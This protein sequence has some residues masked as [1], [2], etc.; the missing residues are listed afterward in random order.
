MKKHPLIVLTALA[1]YAALGCDDTKP[2][3]RLAPSIQTT[4]SAMEF[5]EVPLGG[6]K[7]LPLS[8]EDSGELT[9][10]V[11]AAAPT[12]GSAADD[13]C[14]MVSRVEPSDAPFAPAFGAVTEQGSWLVEAGQK[15]ELLVRFTPKAVG[16][17]SGALQLFNNAG[18]RPTTVLLSGSGVQAD[19]ELSPAA[20]DFGDVTVGEKKSL[21]L[22][23]TNRANFAQSVSVGP[24][25]QFALVF[26]VSDAGGMDPPVG[27][28]LRFELGA[29][30]A[31]TVQVWFG[32]IEEGEILNQLPI[33]VCSVGG[34]RQEV[35]LRGV[36]LKPALIVSPATLDFGALESGLSSSKRFEAKNVGQSAVLVRSVELEAGSS[37]SYVLNPEQALPLSLAP[38]DTL[39]VG[40]R[41]DSGAPGT[42]PARVVV[43]SSAWDD[44]ATADAENAAVVT[45][46]GVSVGADIAALP[47]ALN[48]G[49]VAIGNGMASRVLTLVNQGNAPLTIRQI[50]LNGPSAEIELIRV[51]TTPLTLEGG[52]E[53]QVILRYRPQD[54]G[55][56]EAQVVVRSSDPDSD[57]LVVPVRGSGGTPSGCALTVTPLTVQFGVV[58][59][60]RVATLPVVV[61]DTGVAPCTLSNV[62][63]AGDT[64][65]RALNAAD[66]VLMPG[67]STRFD[68]TYTP[69]ESADASGPVSG[70]MNP[71]AG[72]IASLNAYGSLV[73]DSDDAS[74]PEL[75]VPL[76]GSS[77]VG[78]LHA[79]PSELDFSVIPPGCGSPS[80]AVM[81]Y[82]TGAT[83][84]T[85]L[86]AY[87]D[88]STSSEYELSPAP[89]PS[90]I[91]AGGELRLE[92]RYRPRDVG[93]DLGAL[94]IEHTDSLFPLMIPLRG[95]SD[96]APTLTDRFTQLPAPT[97]DVLFVV[98]NSG[99]MAEEQANLGANFGAFLSYAESTGVD[100]QIAVTTTDVDALGARGHFSR[101]GGSSIITPRTPDA[102]RVFLGNTNV[103][104]NGS[105]TEQ[106][107]EAAFLALSEPLI[108][109]SNR[110]FLRADASL[111]VIVVSDEEDQSGRTPA[112]Y[113]SFFWNIKG[114][115]NRAQFSFSAIV[116]PSANDPLCGSF[117]PSPG[118][119]YI[120][121]AQ[122]TGGVVESICT[123][124]WGA[125]LQNIGLGTFGL[126]SRFTLSAQAIPTSIV[127]SVDGVAMSSAGG[128]QWTYDAATNSLGFRPGFAPI[129]GAVVEVTYQVACVP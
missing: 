45:L 43:R 28:P 6:F 40:V 109:T 60:G 51:P 23:I 59:R 29:N 74:Q 105:S 57:P 18:E 128:A 88:A 102:A 71:P 126:R 16:P 63:V 37:P 93:E 77:A 67:T 73:F 56:D 13:A 112:F 99:S 129:A 11:C 14:T 111:A 72:A 21:E 76:M 127:V 44:P 86:R 1:G 83:A 107:L 96:F 98:D 119:R 70:G 84:V 53:V 38:G 12:E 46:S 92:L 123:A 97:V 89:I 35:G 27:E 79:L 30:A 94:F 48:F 68:L 91:P 47:A 61:S 64:A 85:V 10:V 87:L 54:S 4:P 81:L 80:R 100:Y 15:R 50:Q 26:G 90:S 58:E 108:S 95:R 114:F 78:A 125:T 36:G 113:E 17:I 104:T 49:T 3:R 116:V 117:G 32:P 7:D 122:A 120:E 42:K 8:V 22:T 106:G 101:Q 39:G 115:H 9:L 124:N 66:V 121:V 52:A 25:A 62:R 103:G 65:F 75:R 19:V 5:G 34:C 20:L 24:L 31:V 33:A 41:F 2:L 118:A 82:N 55:P 69:T 110:S